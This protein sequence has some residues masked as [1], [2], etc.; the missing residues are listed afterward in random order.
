MDRKGRLIVFEGIDG[1]GK[2]THIRH[3]AEWMSQFGPIVVTREPAGTELGRAVKPVLDA[4]GF[5]PLV[6]FFFQEALRADHVHRVLKPSLLEG[7][8]VLCDRFEESTNAYQRHAKNVPGD[9]VE[10]ANLYGSG[11]VKADLT[12]LLLLPAEEALERIRS[13]GRPTSY[14][15]RETLERVAQYYGG[16]S[17]LKRPDVVSFDARLPEETLRDKIREAVAERFK[18][19]LSSHPALRGH[20]GR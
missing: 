10:I 20:R 13:R 17:A 4:G 12:I 1:T 15:T 16:L 7:K 14:E 18:I 11:G 9:L 3:L 5:P 2:S 19:P 8:T 6:D